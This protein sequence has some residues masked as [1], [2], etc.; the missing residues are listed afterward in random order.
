MHT[1]SFQYPLQ[2]TNWIRALQVML[3]RASGSTPLHFDTKVFLR[4]VLLSYRLIFGQH[5]PSRKLYWKC[6]RKK[7]V[8]EG[9]VDPFL[10]ILCGSRLLS[11][12]ALKHLVYDNDV[13]RV[14]GDFPTLGSRLCHLQQYNDAYHPGR[15]RELWNDRRNPLQWFTFWVVII[16]G[17]L[18]ILLSTAQV[19]ISAVSLAVQVK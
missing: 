12:P 18:S 11:N 1:I 2:S 3:E 16:F 10:D 13:Y 15:I 7:L 4:E 14:A 5:Q 17:G 9:Q 6:E 19:V 8:K